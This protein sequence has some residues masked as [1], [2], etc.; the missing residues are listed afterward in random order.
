MATGVSGVLEGVSGFLGKDAV[1]G[2]DAVSVLSSS[3]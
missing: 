3:T 2:V 1:S